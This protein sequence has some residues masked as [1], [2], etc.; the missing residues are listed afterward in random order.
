MLRFLF[1]ILFTVMLFLLGRLLGPRERP[2]PSSGERV[3]PSGPSDPRPPRPSRWAG[4]GPPPL[5][6]SDVLDVPFTEIPSAPSEP[7][8]DAGRP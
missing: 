2:R 4:K 6:R 5:D 1:R 7:A 8:S 3:Q